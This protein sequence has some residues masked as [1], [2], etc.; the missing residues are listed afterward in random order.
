MRDGGFPL[1]GR[2]ALVR[3]LLRLID[4]LPGFYLVGIAT[5][6]VTGSG[7]RIG[8]YAAG[9]IVVRERRPE[10]SPP[11]DLPPPGLLRPDEASLVLEFLERREGL[12]AA[13]RDRLARQI[14][15]PIARRLGRPDPALPEAFLEA[16]YVEC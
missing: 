15:D 8:D 1:D 11:L 7:K 2:G 9:T 14:A 16:V 13:A 3:N 6:F 4:A 10:A 5:L 12:D